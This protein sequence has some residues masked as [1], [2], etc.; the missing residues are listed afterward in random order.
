[1]FLLAI[2]GLAQQKGPPPPPLVACGTHQSD[3]DILCGAR[4]P[5]DLEVTPDNKLLI[6]SQ[7]VNNRGTPGERA[8][9]ALFDLAKN[10]YPNLA[11][12]EEPRKDWGDP[13]CPGPIGNKLVPHGTSLA[14]R[15]NAWQ[16]FVVN[17]GGRESIEMYELKQTGGNWSAVWHGCVVSMQAFNDVAAL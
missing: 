13:A 3:V 8:G 14:K 5:E 6:V 12:S 9:L 7:M 4:S 15:G 10:E 11:L 16:L 17:H 1:L 2:T